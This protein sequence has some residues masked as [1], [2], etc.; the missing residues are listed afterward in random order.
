M[1][2]GSICS[3]S[4]L[5]AM[6]L[7]ACVSRCNRSQH[8]GRSSPGAFVAIIVSLLFIIFYLR[9]VHECER[10][11]GGSNRAVPLPARVAAAA[12]TLLC[13]GWTRS[14]LDRSCTSR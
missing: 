6:L 9:S 7:C 5:I 10:S 14:R 3:L 11:M 4:S 1:H 12:S 13:G 2:S 8:T